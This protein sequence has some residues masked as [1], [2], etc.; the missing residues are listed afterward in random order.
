MT[1]DRY[2][3]LKLI[4]WW[5]Q[6]KVSRAKYMVVG[7]GALGNEILKNL[8]LVG[9]GHIFVVDFDVVEASNLTR[10]VL[11][12]LGDIGKPKAQVAAKR[13]K[14]LNPDVKTAFF[15]GDITS[16]VGL[17][18]FREFDAVFIGVDNFKARIFISRACEKTGVPWINGGIQEMIGE[19]YVFIPGRG[20]CYECNL[21]QHAYKEFNNRL[22]CL[23]PMEEIAEGKVPTTPT[24]ASIIAAIQVQEALKLLHGADVKGGHGLIFNGQNNECLPVYFPLNDKCVCHHLLDP[25]TQINTSVTI[26]TVKEA[27]DLFHEKSGNEGFIE[28]DFD[29]VHRLNCTC[30]TSVECAKRLDKMKPADYQCTACGKSMEPGMTSIID[31]CFLTLVDKPLA[32]CCIPPL[33]IITVRNKSSIYHL[34][35]TGEKE[36]IINFS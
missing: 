1:E 4:P 14:E 30:G 11:F 29:L 10:S 8:A 6:A 22:S 24:I 28:L 5:D 35:F 15:T 26:C 2:S 21:P 25:V 3:S 20:A 19:A 32:Q 23:L 27:L 9:A 16:D 17:G 33:E 18:A 34:E 31:R 13:I 12:R 36:E 7:A